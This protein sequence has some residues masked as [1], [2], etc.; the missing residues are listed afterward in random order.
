[1]R[2][3]AQTLLKEDFDLDVELPTN[4]LIP[5]VP[6]RLNY[7]LWIDELLRHNGFSEDVVGIDIGARSLGTRVGSPDFF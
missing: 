2:V 6:Q 3:L 4:S 5:R 7:V 1:M